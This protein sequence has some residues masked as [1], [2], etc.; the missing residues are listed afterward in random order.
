M[1]YGRFNSKQVYVHAWGL[2]KKTIKVSTGC[3][4]SRCDFLFETK[5][6]K[7]TMNEDDIKQEIFK[8]RMIRLPGIGSCSV[9][10]YM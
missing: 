5:C 9:Y 4:Q 8:S 1:I 6:E 10:N 3:F 2:Q 7:W